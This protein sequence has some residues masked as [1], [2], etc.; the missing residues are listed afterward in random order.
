M[1]GQLRGHHGHKYSALRPKNK[2]IIDPFASVHKPL[3]LELS[4]SVG[5]APAF[6]PSSRWPVEPVRATRSTWNRRADDMDRRRKIGSSPQHFTLPAPCADRVARL[7]ET[8]TLAT[9]A[10]PVVTAH[11]ARHRTSSRKRAISITLC[12]PEGLARPL[13]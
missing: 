3:S 10:A 2:V 8:H 4:E 9:A 13:L 6:G 1:E 7:T 11:A 12:Q 5:S